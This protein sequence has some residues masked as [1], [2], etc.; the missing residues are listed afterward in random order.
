MEQRERE[1]ARWATDCSAAQ[2]PFHSV[3]PPV[4]ALSHT[5]MVLRVHILLDLAIDKY[6][7]TRY[8]VD[9]VFLCFRSLRCLLLIVAGSAG[10]AA[11]HT[12]SSTA[13]DTCYRRCEL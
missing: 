3:G 1:S 5:Y 13:G 6:F 8:D 12:E 7:C 9:Y 2:D 11:E 4:V 10:D